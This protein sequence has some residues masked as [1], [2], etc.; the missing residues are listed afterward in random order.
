M[1]RTITEFCR[2][3]LALLITASL[4]ACGTDSGS[5]GDSY[6]DTGENS[7]VGGRDGLTLRLT[8]APFDHAVRVDVWFT[9]VRVKQKD[10][11]WIDIPTRDLKE[12]M[13]GLASLQGTKSLELVSGFELPSGEYTEIRL[14]VDESKSQIETVNG[15]NYTKGGV[16]DLEIP[17]GAN[18]GLIVK[19]NFVISENHGVDMVIDV[20]L[21]RSLEETNS[22]VKPYR[23][24]PRLRA[25]FSSN[26]GHI[27]GKVDGS[28]LVAGSCSDMQA[29]TYNAVYVFKGHDVT[30]DDI[31]NRPIDPDPITTAKIAWDEA[32]MSYVYEAGFLPA[33]NYTIALTCNA[34]KEDLRQYQDDLKFFG[35][36]NV[37]V[38]VNDT[39]FL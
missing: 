10:G 32:T 25:A 1:K 26:F 29:D 3:P 21:R 16:Y 23:M 30:P 9:G 20:D 18:P 28:L 14:L 39:L 12:N 37:V 33:G 5:S 38:K 24:L 13:V 35:I 15:A 11:D 22:P 17:T 34:D 4:A 31:S 2:L 19:E 36:K 7:L 8:D 27:R 6:A